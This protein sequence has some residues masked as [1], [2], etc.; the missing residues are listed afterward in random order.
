MKF[1]T[2]ILRAFLAFAA[3]SVIQSGT[4]MLII[5]P[6]IAPPAQALPWLLLSNAVTVAAL[7]V[8][9][10]RSD[11]RGWRLGA[12]VAAIPA[13]IAGANAIEGTFFLKN[14]GIDWPRLFAYIIISAILAAPVWTLLFGMR[15]AAS[16]E[17][18]RPIASKSRAERAWKF[19]LSDL[20]YALLYLVAG[21]IIF[22][23]VK[24]FYAT[25]ELPS[26]STI[27]GLQL[28][29]RGPIFVVVCLVLVRMLGLPRLSGALAVGAIFAVLNGV[30]PLLIP[31]PVFPDT[32]RWVHMCEVTSSNFVFGIII[33][34]LWGR[35]RP[36]Q[37]LALR[38]A[39]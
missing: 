39:A 18:Y 15:P 5:P 29:V 1:S 30:A 25:Q 3:I 31:N 8:V 6:R 13:I 2:T 7:C 34:W 4:G 26:L 14:S 28:L 19:A 27:L 38:S 9:A 36:V 37:S 11:W 23:Y 17:S 35:P 21:A 33:G 16:S 32:V 12:A 20:A 22:P 10:L 24:S